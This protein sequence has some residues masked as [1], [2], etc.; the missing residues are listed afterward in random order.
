MKKEIKEMIAFM[1]ACTFNG[2][3][4]VQA[5]GNFIILQIIIG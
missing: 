5:T 1:N 2:L 4:K 3:V